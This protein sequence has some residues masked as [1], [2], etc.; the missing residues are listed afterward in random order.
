MD[1]G[2][3]D[4]CHAEDAP[5]DLR[6][7]GV[8]DVTVRCGVVVEPERDAGGDDLPL[9]RL[10][11]LASPGALRDLRPLELGELV[12]MPSASAPPAGRRPDTE[13]F[14]ALLR[15]SERG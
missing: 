14:L 3:L 10:A 2:L 8:D 4:A 15:E 1:R 6:L 5:Q 13:N 9:P 7:L 12:D 11:L